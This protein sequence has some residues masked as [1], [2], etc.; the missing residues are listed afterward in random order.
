MKMLLVVVV[1]LI[2]CNKKEG[3]STSA[4]AGSGSAVAA[5]P[6][7]PVED[8]TCALAS[9]EYTKKM[10]ATPG[11]VLSD[12]KPDDGLIYFTS[13]SM[14]DYC[15]GEDGAVVAWTASERACVKNAAPSAVT[16]CFSGAAL[17]QVNAGLGEVVASALKNRKA[18]E[19]AAGSGSAEK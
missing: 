16:A 12:A 19:A 17:A 15:D 2:G 6:A 1:A 14:E 7:A 9:K 4:P 3:A 13:I 8:V 18:N 10:A 11:N 5:A